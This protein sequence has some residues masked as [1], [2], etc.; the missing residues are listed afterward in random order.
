M[1]DFEDEFPQFPHFWKKN[2]RVTEFDKKK[3]DVITRSCDIINRSCDVTAVNSNFL[4]RS[5][6]S[7]FILLGGYQT[8]S[9]NFKGNKKYCTCQHFN[10]GF[11]WQYDNGVHN[12]T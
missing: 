7:K 6:N 12:I 11:D 8:S 5:C 2:F 1:H 10:C 4:T 3:N 9:N